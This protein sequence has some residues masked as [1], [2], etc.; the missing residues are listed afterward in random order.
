M[1]NQSPRIVLAEEREM[2]VPCAQCGREI[3]LGDPTA[4]C[5]ECGGVHHAPCWHAQ[6][7]CAAYECATTAPSVGV[8]NAAAL[9]ITRGDLAAAVP[10][11]PPR[12]AADTG[13]AESMLSAGTKKRWNRTGVWAFILSI[14]GIPL[15]GLV[16]GLIAMVVGCVAL[17]GHTRHRRGMGLAVAAILIGLLEVV[18]WAV[19]LS[20]FLG[21]SP[22]LVAL[23][24]MTIDPAS[25]KELPERLARSMRANVL[26]ETRAG[27]GR[28]IGSGV[29]LR[30]LDGSAYIVTNRHV[31]DRAFANGSTKVP[32]DLS[33]LGDLTVMTVEQV[34]V[35]GRV[36]WIAP[37]GIDL[38]IVS[39]PIVSDEVRE[40]HWSADDTPH[41]GD[42]VYAVGNPHG[43]GWTHSA[44]DISQVRQRSE[45]GFT[46]RILQTTAAINPGNSGGGLYDEKGRLIGI[47]TLTGD[48]RFAEGLGFSIALPALLQLV[49]QHLQ[50]PRKNPPNEITQEAKFE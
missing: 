48:K 10:L 3:R 2:G 22:S 43:L 38:A 37:H 11:P 9:Q 24:Q 1:A 41:V 6:R 45:D 47:N 4:I 40:A 30:L 17:A 20:Y 26:I 12:S 16:T 32:E 7:G 34:P 18:G 15:F 29:V 8:E 23:E 49:P 46:Y 19:G 25:L 44:G 28:G 14:V 33:D 39:A 13:T 21:A 5:R 31:I 42:T 36:E 50:V 35:R 27:F